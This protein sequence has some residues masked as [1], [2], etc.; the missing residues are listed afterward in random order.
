[1]IGSST[2]IPGG[3]PRTAS[4]WTF[5]GKGSFPPELDEAIVGAA[6]VEPNMTCK[7]L[8]R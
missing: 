6:V 3:H 5:L 1:M 7:I 2:H 8:D 4:K